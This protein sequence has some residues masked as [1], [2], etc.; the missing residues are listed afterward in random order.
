[1]LGHVVA[2]RL[3]EAGHRVLVSERRYTGAPRDPLVEEVRDAGAEW[4]VN[5]IGLTARNANPP[6]DLRVVNTD[7]PLHLGRRLRPGQRLIHASTDGVFAGTRGHYATFDD[8]D[9]TDAY[10]WSKALGEAVAARGRAW[11]IRTS[12]I[13]P[14]LGGGHGLLGWLLRQNGKATGYTN[15]RWNGITTLAWAGLA[16][17]IIAEPGSF[18]A[19]LLQAGSTIPVTKCELLRAISR[20]WPHPIEIVEA[21]APE[22]VDRTLVPDVDLGPIADQLA[23]LAAWYR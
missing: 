8:A 13:G 18:P 14:D 12:I 3:A 17:R 23:A 5:A 15:H 20:A 11:V 6:S 9:A 4:V 19:P 7:L 22:A 1:M 16:A 21:A 10:G 2:R